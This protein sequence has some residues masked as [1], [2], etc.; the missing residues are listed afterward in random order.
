[1]TQAA[2]PL[3]AQA[4][5][6]FNY[7]LLG[8]RLQRDGQVADS[9]FD[10]ANRLL[11]D[12]EF[13]YSYDDNGNMIEKTQVTTS[14]VTKYSYDAENQLTRIDFPDGTNAQYRYDA[15]GRRIEKNSSGALTRYVY[16]GEDILFEFDGANILKARYAHGAGIDKPLF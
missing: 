2:R 16:D 15:L 14:Q 12:Q 11:E 13:K 4:D 7:D 1:M 9:R 3:P 6:T 5:E 8:N 10:A